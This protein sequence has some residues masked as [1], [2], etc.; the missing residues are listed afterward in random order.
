MMGR[1]ELWHDDNLVKSLKW[2]DKPHR[3]EIIKQYKK[4]TEK[5]WLQC[6]IIITYTQETFD[7]AAKL[8]QTKWV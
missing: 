5:S 8:G 3:K 2:K 1:I 4:M 6:H 7:Y